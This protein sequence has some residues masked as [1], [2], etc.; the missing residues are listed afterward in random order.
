MT[1]VCF[2][3]IG[4]GKAQ[5]PRI[6]LI[7]GAEWKIQEWKIWQIAKKSGTYENDGFRIDCF[8]LGTYWKPKK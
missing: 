1:Q 2:A 3:M 5:C 4:M 8:L 7:L 6:G